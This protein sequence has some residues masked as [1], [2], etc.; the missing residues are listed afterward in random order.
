MTTADTVRSLVTTQL[1]E[2][3][4]R[5]GAVMRAISAMPDE[6]GPSWGPVLAAAGSLNG[7]LTFGRDIVISI[8]SSPETGVA[9]EFIDDNN[10]QFGDT[11]KAAST[12]PALWSKTSRARLAARV[13]EIQDRIIY[14]QKDIAQGGSLIGATNLAHTVA[15]SL[16]RTVRGLQADITGQTAKPTPDRR[17]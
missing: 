13:E 7:A 2:A 11:Y 3:S 10:R 8:V 9:P 15:D 16:Q 5:A 1:T 14:L 6:T 17:R 12:A 4:E